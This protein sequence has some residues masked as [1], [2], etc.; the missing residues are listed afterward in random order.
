MGSDVDRHWIRPV[1]VRQQFAYR[2]TGLPAATFNAE[3]AT[4]ISDTKSYAKTELDAKTAIVCLQR[5]RIQP[6][7]ERRLY[8]MAC[9]R[10]R[11]CFGRWFQPARRRRA[12]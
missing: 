12:C 1:C 7:F 11:A 2:A 6:R 10:T 3:T 8:C 5:L 4:N 9:L